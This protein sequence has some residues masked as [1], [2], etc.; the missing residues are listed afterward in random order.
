MYRNENPSTSKVNLSSII[1]KE[2]D[3][4]VYV[5][6]VNEKLSSSGNVINASDSGS[7]LHVIN[8]EMVELT[9]QKS[10]QDESSKM[11]HTAF[12]RQRIQNM[13]VFGNKW[14]TRAFL[15]YSSSSPLYICATVNYAYIGISQEW[16]QILMLFSL[17][18]LCSFVNPIIYFWRIPE[19]R[20][21]LTNK[22]KIR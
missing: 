9:D 7:T 11:S 21:T 17:P 19:F 22:C 8:Q 4:S 1:D 15:Y 3:P 5:I 2:V 14:A 12:K 18:F 6:Y 20:Q 13:K 16:W 10:N